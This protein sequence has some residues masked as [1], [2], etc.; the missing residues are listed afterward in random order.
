LP[1]SR[2]YRDYLAWLAAADR[3]AAKAFWRNR[4]AGVAPSRLALVAGDPG[5]SPDALGEHRVTLSE[6][7]SGELQSLGQA[8]RLTVSAVMQGAWA[9]LLGRHMS[10]DD[11]MFGMT[12]AGRP[13]ELAGI[14]RMVG[15]CINT[16]PRRVRLDPTA[17]M[18][19]WLGLLQ[20]RQ[21]EEQSHDWCSLVDIQRWCSTAADTALFDSVVVFENYPVAPSLAGNSDA[22]AAELSVSAVA[23]FEEGIHFPLCLVVGPG[24]TITLRLAFS[25]QRFD[26]EAVKRLADDLTRLL[27]AIATDPEQRLAKLWP[28]PRADDARELPA[29]RGRNS[30]MQQSHRGVQA[31][32]R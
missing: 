3:P 11:V 20:A 27:A 4:L 17:R 10:R 22:Q 25:R 31:S 30:S 26:V 16:L 23:G 7:L 21:V 28:H 6:Q 5:A 14:E 12:T 13:G 9:L 2:P 15:L 8:R 29:W 32:A 1:P 18:S 24:R 19:D